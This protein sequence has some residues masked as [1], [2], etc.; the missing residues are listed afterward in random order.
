[1]HMRNIILA[2]SIMFFS[3]VLVSLKPVNLIWQY[4]RTKAWEEDWLMELLAGLNVR[5]IDDT[6]FEIYRNYSIIVAAAGQEKEIVSYCKKF[7]ER[8]YKFGVILLYDED[9]RGTSAYYE[10]PLFIFKNY[11]HKQYAPYSQITCF[12]LGYKSGFWSKESQKILNTD[13][14]KYTWSF[15]GQIARRYTEEEKKN[16]YYNSRKDMF[17][18]M[19]RVSNN[20]VYPI[21]GWN[22][23]QSLKVADYQ[24]LMLNSIFIPCPRGHWNLES[25]RLSEALECGCIPIVETEPIDYYRKFLGDHPFITVRTWDEAP[26]KIEELLAD[27]V[28]LEERRQKC[29]QWWAAYK[30]DMKQLFVKTVCKA[31]EIA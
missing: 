27:R 22:S 11:W 12:L 19:K 5:V 18:Y 28:A 25:Y 8:G 3:N 15:A 1:M 26:E 16:K 13:Q 31:F 24:D 7:K 30:N 20:F 9:Y 2:I 23:P 10:Y 14:R 29:M 21:Y 4:D 6:R 17:K